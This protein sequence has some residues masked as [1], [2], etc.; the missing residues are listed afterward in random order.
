[1]ESKVNGKS[2]SEGSGECSASHN[3][4]FFFPF[5]ILSQISIRLPPIYL[6][7]FSNP[8]PSIPKTQFLQPT[9]PSLFLLIYPILVSS[10]LLSSIP[11]KS[12]FLYPQN[13]I[14]STQLALFVLVSALEKLQKIH[15]QTGPLESICIAGQCP[16]Q[17]PL[18]YIFFPFFC[19]FLCSAVVEF[20]I[21][22]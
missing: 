6:N 5:I 14:P 8:L 20:L 22:F 9:S 10:N 18:S 15:C 11:F 12:I 3:V 7:P 13:S 19:S 21:D 1:M 4:R 16:R 2:G 17:Y